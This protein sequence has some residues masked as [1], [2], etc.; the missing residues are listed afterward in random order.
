[1]GLQDQPQAAILV[2]DDEPIVHESVQ[3]ILSEE[4]YLVD[5]DLRVKD[6]LERLKKTPYDLVLTDLMMP[7]QN[8]LEAVKAIGREHPGIGVVMFTG[9]PKV[10]SAVES[11]KLGSLDYL[12]KPFTPDE[13][14]AVVVRSLEKVQKA[15]RDRELEQLFV[16][17]DKAIQSS[18]DL[19][20]VLQII[21]TNIVRIFQAKGS[22]VFLYNKRTN[23]LDLNSTC[24]LSDGYLKKGQLDGARSIPEVL[25]SSEPVCIEAAL[26]DQHLQYPEEA[27]KEGLSAILSLPLGIDEKPLGVLRLY[28][29]DARSFTAEEITV[30]KRLADLAARAIQNAKSF[31]RI[32]HDMEELKKYIPKAKE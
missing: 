3:R 25:A 31:Q 27:R 17:A 18:L 6:A 16:E 1:M 22:A 11:I 29:A 19:K 2:I 24:G 9:Y 15:R 8:G 5:G 23:S 20:E 14:I 10:D 4:G 28:R 7:E 32:R 12:P 30:L 21:N 26:F 13:L